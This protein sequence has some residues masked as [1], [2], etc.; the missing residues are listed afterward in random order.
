[1]FSLYYIVFIAC[2]LSF[3]N[4]FVMMH[5]SATL[6]ICW[7]ILHEV[8][9]QPL[10]VC[11]LLNAIYNV[12]VTKVQQRRFKPKKIVYWGSSF[13]NLST[14]LLKFQQSNFFFV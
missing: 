4:E 2:D 6:Y 8:N 11:C 7:F 9:L 13:G 5:V 1:M 10:G 12:K 3:F 14:F